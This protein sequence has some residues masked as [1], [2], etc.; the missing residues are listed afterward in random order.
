M[1][2]PKIKAVSAVRKYEILVQFEDGNSGNYD[3]S[4]LAGKGVFTVWDNGNTFFDVFISADSG[5]I[6][7]PGE[8]DI[9][10]ITVYCKIKGIEVQTYLKSSSQHASYI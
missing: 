1:I 8:L 2:T 6:T 3:L 9:D 10:T 4:H 7:W 5:A